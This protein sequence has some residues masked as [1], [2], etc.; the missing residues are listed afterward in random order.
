MN[1]D[2][3]Y[4]FCKKMFWRQIH[5]IKLNTVHLIDGRGTMN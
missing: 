1:D 3:N 5:Q 4:G 2:N